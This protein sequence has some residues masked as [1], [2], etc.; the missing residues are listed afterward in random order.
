M[1]KR[2]VPNHQPDEIAFIFLKKK[3][4]IQIAISRKIP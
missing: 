1:E 4:A 3:H 2:N